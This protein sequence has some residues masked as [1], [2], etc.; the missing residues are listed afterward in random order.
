MKGGWKREGKKEVKKVRIMKD[1][2]TI[3]R[4]K[5]GALGKN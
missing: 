3:R 1:K 2:G 4:G 5:K